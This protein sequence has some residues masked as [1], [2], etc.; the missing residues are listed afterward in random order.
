MASTWGLSATHNKWFRNAWLVTALFVAVY[1]AVQPL[2]QPNGVS[3]PMAQFSAYQPDALM[4]QRSE[5]AG[6][7]GGVEAEAKTALQFT[8]SGEV[9]P[10]PPL[11]PPGSDDRK[12]IRSNSLDLIVQNPAEMVEKIRR[13]AEG[14]GGFLVT[15]Q[16]NGAENT[17]SGSLTV[18]VPVSHFDE[19]RA[20]IRKLGI[21]VE[22]DRIEA[23][24]VTRQYVDQGSR[25]RNLHAMEDQYLSI[26]KRATTVKDTLDVSE[27]LNDVRGQIE[28]QQAEFN[29]LSKQ[30]ETVEIAVQLRTETETQVFGLNW[31][32]LSRLKMALRD[33]L[34]GIGTYMASMANILFYL[35]AVL[36]WLGTILLGA[37][38]AWRVLRWT[39]RTFFAGPAVRIEKV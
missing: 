10:A 17:S 1:V 4:A 11:P 2:R 22:S 3:Q 36:L 32:P 33:G 8:R 29:A 34:D 20:Q 21:R 38:L 28:E 5:P 16:V 15:S 19:V 39:T 30:V 25:L 12:F 27:K 9:H 37:A 23:Q 13:L 6:V 24:D 7:I 31:R 26:M 35:P 18:R 14:F